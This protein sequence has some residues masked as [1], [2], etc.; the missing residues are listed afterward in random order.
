MDYLLGEFPF[1]T[2]SNDDFMELV[3]PAEV[4]HIGFIDFET[5]RIIL[6]GDDEYYGGDYN[7]DYYNEHE[8]KPLWK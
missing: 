5:G 3:D 7:D 2:L 6:S 8:Y 1:A 4:W